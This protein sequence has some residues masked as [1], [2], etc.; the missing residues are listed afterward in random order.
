VPPRRRSRNKPALGT[1]G[2]A[3]LIGLAGG[4]D[5]GLCQSLQRWRGLTIIRAWLERAAIVHV[6]MLGLRRT[7]GPV[8]APLRRL[9]LRS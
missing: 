8:Y 9:S 6:A 5:A 1:A 2:R 4:A 7:F 3:F